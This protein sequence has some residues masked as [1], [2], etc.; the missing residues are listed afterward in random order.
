MVLEVP[1]PRQGGRSR[2][3]AVLDIR[4]GDVDGDV[5]VE[6][7]SGQGHQGHA[8]HGYHRAPG[9]VAVQDLPGG[10]PVLVRVVP[11]D[12]PQD[13]G[14]RVERDRVVPRGR[15]VGADHA[16]PRLHRGLPAHG[17]EQQVGGDPRV[18]SLESGE[19]RVVHGHVGP[20]EAAVHHHLR[21]VEAQTTVAEVHCAPGDR[22]AQVRVR[23]VGVGGRGLGEPPARRPAEFGHPGCGDGQAVRGAVRPGD[24]LPRQT[25]VDRLDERGDLRDHATGVTRLERGGRPAAPA[26]GPP[27]PEGGD[28]P[29]RAEPGGLDADAGQVHRSGEL[30]GSCRADRHLFS[31]RPSRSVWL[32]SLQYPDKPPL[33][34]G[35]THPGRAP[36]PVLSPVNG[37]ASA[38]ALEESRV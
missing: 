23:P 3:T 18:R 34:R 19:P 21:L 20:G 7:R 38:S 1:Q 5:P 13:P 27:P 2:Q 8:H 9:G 30:S 35:T 15:G 12:L 32:V 33:V 11:L 26:L 25:G 36:G 4:I 31:L 37:C 6:L 17:V 29:V 14:Q 24:E 16:H 28:G 10:F 22:V